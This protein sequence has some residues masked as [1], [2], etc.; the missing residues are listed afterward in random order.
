[1]SAWIVSKSHIDCIVQSLI[2]EKLI[3][4]VEADDT[5]QMLWRECL[6]SVAY[7]YPGDGDGERPGPNDFR[8]C[9]VDEYRFIGIEAPLD[10][11]IVAKQ[12]A[13]FQYQSCEHPA[14]KVS[15]AKVLTD[16]LAERIAARHGGDPHWWSTLTDARG[17]DGLPWGID[18]ITE[19]IAR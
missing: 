13:C 10:D 5:G 7:R 11:A 14:W 19:A 18:N 9:H 16:D 8:D 4:V 2:I 3:A 17:H 6:R 12:I 15:A 1:M